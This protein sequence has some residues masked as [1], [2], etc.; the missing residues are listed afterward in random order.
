MIEFFLCT[1]IVLLVVLVAV[2][3]KSLNETKKLA[4]NRLLLIKDWLDLLYVFSDDSQAFHN[5][6]KNIAH[7]RQ[8][9][10]YNIVSWNPPSATIKM[11]WHKMS[12]SERQF[13]C[14]MNA[15][16]SNRELCAIFQ[17]GKILVQSL[18]AG[19]G[20]TAIAA[21]AIV[22]TGSLIF[23]GFRPGVSRDSPFSRFETNNPLGEIEF[24]FSR[25]EP[26]YYFSPFLQLIPCN[27][28]HS[29]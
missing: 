20:T 1:I 15:G 13:I 7:I 23:S 17:V 25:Q 12:V 16:F 2:L 22:G 10:K 18:I 28:I 4:S 3:A 24:A 11:K 5:R 26:A 14:L 9:T 27:W 8:L 6:C 29:V 21:N 19:L